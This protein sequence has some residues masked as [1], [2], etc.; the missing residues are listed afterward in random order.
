M[1]A[2]CRGYLKSDEDGGLRFVYQEPGTIFNLEAFSDASFSPDG[3]PSHGCLVILLNGAAVFWR[4]GKQQLV[5]LSTAECELVEFV[6][7]ITAGESI[8]VVLQELTS[9]VRKIGWCDSK[10]ALGILVN[11]GGNWRTRQLVLSGE[12]LACHVPGSNMIADLGTKALSS[13]KIHQL[14]TALG[15]QNPPK[16]LFEVDREES[17]ESTRTVRTQL[18]SVRAQRLLQ[19]LSFLVVI[20]KAKGEDESDFPE[21]GDEI[22]NWFPLLTYT[23]CIIGLTMMMNW[24]LGWI[25]GRLKSKAVVKSD[26]L[27]DGDIDEDLSSSRDEAQGGSE[28]HLRRPADLPQ[29]DQS[30]LQVPAEPKG[31][32]VPKPPQR[33]PQQGAQGQEEDPGRVEPAGP[34]GRGG[35]SFC[36]HSQRKREVTGWCE[37]TCDPAQTQ[38]T[39][40]DTIV[41]L[42]GMF[43][44]DSKIEIG[45][46]CSASC[47]EI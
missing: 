29:Q 47:S 28:L 5:T 42:Y 11:E 2:Q 19:L 12:W 32:P 31:L 4:S 9:T 36:D 13:V 22:K 20:E 6:N 21:R 35:R 37:S 30:P 45:S 17:P 25:Q 24:C 26:A 38:A 33:C 10:A 15:M 41:E 27:D 18:D 39:G 8:A 16:V 46:S 34:K 44:W 3:G 40:I 23:F 14:R 43:G 7:T 1:A